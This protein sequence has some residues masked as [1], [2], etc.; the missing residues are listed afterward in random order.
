MGA[1]KIYTCDIC[2]TEIKDPKESFGIHFTNNTAFTLG[3]YG[4]TD[5]THICFRC[6]R[7]LKLHLNNPEIQKC[8]TDSNN[9]PEHRPES[10]EG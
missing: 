7:Q 10:L 2:R 5:G 6:A 4:C 8:L 3:G 9:P 1:K